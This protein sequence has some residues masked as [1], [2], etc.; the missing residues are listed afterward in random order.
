MGAAAPV[1]T[2]ILPR[3]IPIFSAMPAKA[4]LLWAK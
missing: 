1:Y 3:K 2:P 4:L